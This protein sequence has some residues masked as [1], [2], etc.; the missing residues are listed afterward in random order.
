M[1][2]DPPFIDEMS[3]P[4]MLHLE[5]IRSSIPRGNIDSVQIDELPEGC[6]VLRE[7][8]IA[9]KKYMEIFGEK[10]PLLSDSAIRYEGQP[11]M[12]IAAPKRE[13]LDECRR[14]VHMEY[15]TDY[16]L[17]AFEPYGEEQ[18]ADTVVFE[19]GNVYLSTDSQYQIIEAEY[20]TTP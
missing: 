19:K 7:G 9:W 2:N 20:S 18:V 15:R 13:Q 8:D 1:S 3:K 16:S 12:L 17:L 4:G 6:F 10:M 11:L 14:A 5:I